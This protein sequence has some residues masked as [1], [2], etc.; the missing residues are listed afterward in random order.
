MKRV[1]CLLFTFVLLGGCSKSYE[2]TLTEKPTRGYEN[3]YEWVDL[4]LS[5]KWASCNIGAAYSSDYGEYIAWGDI[6]EKSSYYD[7]N[8]KTSGV[9]YSNLPSSM[10]AARERWGGKW[11]MP[12][13]ENVRELVNN[14]SWRWTSRS[15]VSG[16]ECTGPNGNKIF[17]P[18]G[19]LAYGLDVYD[20]CTSGYFWTAT[21]TQEDGEWKDKRSYM[22]YY[23]RNDD[24]EPASN[25][26]AARRNGL[27]IRPVMN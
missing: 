18:A 3:G 8:C 4:G 7:D 11:R 27:N 1:I 16:Y 6:Y 10:D 9:S 5:V 15:G 23:N 17:F 26:C 25:W 21:P 19:G 20:E 24:V 13:R 14:C 12:T 22:F 2:F